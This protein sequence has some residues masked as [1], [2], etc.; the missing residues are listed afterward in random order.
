MLNSRIVPLRA[1]VFLLSVAALAESQSAAPLPNQPMTDENRLLV[2]RSLNAEFVFVR[3][4]LPMGQKGLAIKNGVVSPD[5]RELDLLIA[6]N[7]LA[8]KP[9][10]RAQITNVDIKDNRIIFEINGGGK[11]KT[12][13]Y[14]RIQIS[15]MGGTVQAPDDAAKVAR[16]SFVELHFDKFVPNMTG[17]QIRELLSPVFNFK[18]LSAAEAY[19]DTVPPKVKE[20]IKNHQVLVGMNREMVGYAKGRPDK[21]IREQDENG[22][23][24][25]E[26]MYGA[27]PQEVQF[28]RFQ[29]DEVVRLTIMKV[30]GEKIVRTQKEIDLSPATEVAEKTEDA[31]PA[32]RP[33]KAPS[34]KRPGEKDDQIPV[35]PSTPAQVPTIPDPPKNSP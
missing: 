4:P 21:K 16:G 15:G 1:A 33:A 3:R 12:K 11:K 28:V 24:Y 6:K 5:Q 8:A 19:L 17:D 23:P 9:G 34:L 2:V 35:G 27:P 29:G 10:D 7:G 32:K 13:W 18:A 26:W 20:A 31:E 22:R 30:D 25:E 14:Q